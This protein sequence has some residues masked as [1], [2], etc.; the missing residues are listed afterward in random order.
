MVSPAYL[1]IVNKNTIELN[2]KDPETGSKDSWNQVNKNVRF[3]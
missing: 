2:N 3:Q 1:K